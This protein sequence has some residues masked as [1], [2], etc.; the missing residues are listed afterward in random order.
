MVLE[1][2]NANESILTSQN[3]NISI[4]IE[5]Q[6]RIIWPES[7][8]DAL[9]PFKIDDGS[10]GS[11]LVLRIAGLDKAE[12][13]RTI[14]RGW[15]AW[16]KWRGDDL[17]FRH[18]DDSLPQLCN[19]YQNQARVL[20]AGLLDATIIETG[21]EVFQQILR[22]IGVHKR[23]KK[24]RAGSLPETAEYI[25][26][27]LYNLA[28]KV[29][30]IRLPTMITVGNNSSDSWDKMA[31]LLS[32][33]DKAAPAITQRQVTKELGIDGT[34]TITATETVVEQDI[35]KEAKELLRGIMSKMGDNGTDNS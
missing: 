20:R 16:Q 5:P 33:V 24:V 29:A 35:N 7:I 1:M 10:K 18:L 19:L 30:S 8:L 31:K 2:T 23:N 21:I 4:I 6:D 15:K 26:D 32:Q 25:P 22:N 27:G 34:Q 3:N 14:D 13:L 17:D 11:Y 12:T 9:K 28:I